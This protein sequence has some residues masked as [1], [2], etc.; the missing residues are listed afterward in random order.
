VLL[1]SIGGLK[2]VHA[3]HGWTGISAAVSGGSTAS[4][5]SETQFAS[6]L[7]SVPI[8]GRWKAKTSSFLLLPMWLV[9][10]DGIKYVKIGSLIEIEI[11]FG[12]KQ[13][14]RLKAFASEM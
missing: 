2:A 14:G 12:D 7:V 4:R 9:D 1:N 10:I 6:I 8:S 11:G 13:S 3:Q 5:W